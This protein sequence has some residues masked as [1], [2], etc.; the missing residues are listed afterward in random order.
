[1]TTK[2]LEK[3]SIVVNDLN[4][5]DEEGNLLAAD[6]F[7]NRFSNL[8]TIDLKTIINGNLLGLSNTGIRASVINDL[9]LLKSKKPQAFDWFFYTMLLSFGE[10]AIFTNETK[11]N[12][13]IYD[14]NMAGFPQPIKADTIFRLVEI[15]SLTMSPPKVFQMYNMNYTNTFV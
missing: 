9:K 1:M 8:M 14:G 10:T 6:Y 13:R 11:T 15:K 4:I 2:I 3:N 5:M 7:S 12:Y